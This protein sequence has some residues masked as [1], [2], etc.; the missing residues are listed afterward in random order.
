[1][2]GNRT[3]RAGVCSRIRSEIFENV[4]ADWFYLTQ[5]S[6]GDEEF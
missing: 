6:I 1:M 3:S 5:Y 4:S 2:E